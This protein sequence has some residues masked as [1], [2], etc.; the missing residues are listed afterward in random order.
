[1]WEKKK[2][3]PSEHWDN[4]NSYDSE[5]ILTLFLAWQ[6]HL[7]LH[8]TLIIIS[9]PLNESPNATCSCNSC[10]NF[11]WFL[12]LLTHPK[13]ST[14]E[15]PPC[16]VKRV[17]IWRESTFFFGKPFSITAFSVVRSRLKQLRP[18]VSFLSVM[19]L[20]KTINFPSAI[21][22]PISFPSYSGSWDTISSHSIINLF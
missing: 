21:L 2:R 8:I 6:P 16:Y 7:L 9:F 20:S 10:F 18:N 4:H 11:N 12:L 1:M 3:I 14:T 19:I 13:K 22:I 5:N 15:D 17:T